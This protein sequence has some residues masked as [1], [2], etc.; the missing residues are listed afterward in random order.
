MFRNTYQS[1]YSSGSLSKTQFKSSNVVNQSQMRAPLYP[2]GPMLTQPETKTYQ[3]GMSP[4][5]SRQGIHPPSYEQRYLTQNS[6]LRNNMSSLTLGDNNMTRINYED[7]EKQI[8]QRNETEI[9]EVQK[10]R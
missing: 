7:R 3:R 10:K 5:V 6:M 2:I 4:Y 9:E 1:N 8:I